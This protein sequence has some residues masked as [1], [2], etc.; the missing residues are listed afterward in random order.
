[1]GD[2]ERTV[3]RYIRRLSKW[4]A[5]KVGRKP[6]IKV[7]G[8]LRTGTNYMTRLLELNFDVFCL[9]STENGWKHGKC[10][11]NE[12]LYY[13][14]MV[15]NPYSW[16]VSFREWEQLHGR[17]S[18]NTLTEFMSGSVTHP[19]LKE[20]WALDNPISAWS[21]ALNSWSAYQGL[22]NVVFVRYEDLIDSYDEQLCRIGDTFGFS[23]RW[24][25]FRNLEARADSWKTPRPRR[26]L[27]RDFYRNEE[28][29]QLFTENDMALI[30]ASLNRE[31][32]ES[33]GYKV[34]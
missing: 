31:L 25:S 4:H 2:M 26:K 1:M 27:S 22:S 24:E 16:I 30:R 6:V 34:L 5:I 21:I 8:L 29:L 19:Q 9:A 20:A 11:Y 13:V 3:Q 28:Y 10:Q 12:K 32:V 18:D 33:Y 23:K 17:S 14:F 7:Y 15:K